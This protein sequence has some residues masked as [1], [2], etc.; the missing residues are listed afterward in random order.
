MDVQLSGVDPAPL[1]AR[2]DTAHRL[3]PGTR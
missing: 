2:L 1:T 3:P